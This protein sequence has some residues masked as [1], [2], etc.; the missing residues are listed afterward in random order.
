MSIRKQKSVL[1]SW[2]CHFV[3]LVITLIS[4]KIGIIQIPIGYGNIMF[5][6]LLYSMLMALMLALF[7][8]FK[9]ISQEYSD[10]ADKFIVIGIA[11]FGAKIGIN[12]GAAII[13]VIQA[14]PALILQEL[15]NLGTIFVALPVA[16]MLGFKREA[17]GMTNSI[18]REP[19]IGLIADVYGMKS[20]EGRGIMITYTVG[21]LIGTIFMGTMASL[22]ASLTPIHPYAYAMACGVGSGS[23]M[24]A[25]VAPLMEAFPHMA[26]EISAYAGISN[27]LSTADGI[28]MTMFIGLPICNFMYKHLEPR[29]GKTTSATIVQD[30]AENKGA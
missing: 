25:S 15:G 7:K 27:L 18:G 8:P 28:F 22:L 29:I 21:T 16:L 11:I 2:E 10:V 14:G 17:V 12:S 3:I 5:L 9:W 23:M 13:S 30:V 19:N 24:A 20:P 4:E 6:P 1:T 26:S